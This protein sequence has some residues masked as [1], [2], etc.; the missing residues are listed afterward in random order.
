MT[1][2]ID[3]IILVIMVMVKVVRW[4]I[5]QVIYTKLVDTSWLLWWG[6]TLDT[7]CTATVYYRIL[8][9]RHTAKN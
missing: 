5:T 1:R 2:E 9:S 7:S 8:T 3:R 4:S 6:R